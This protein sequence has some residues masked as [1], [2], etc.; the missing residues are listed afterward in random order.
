MHVA[1]D[2]SRSFVSVGR[3]G[4]LFWC[5]FPSVTVGGP[6]AC[7]VGGTV[8]V[9]AVV[10]ARGTALHALVSGDSLPNVRYRHL[11][12]ARNNPGGLRLLHA[13]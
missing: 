9:R 4:H 8:V 5:L 6:L 12:Y 1:S 13:L 2:V 10:V 7:A 3:E 11:L